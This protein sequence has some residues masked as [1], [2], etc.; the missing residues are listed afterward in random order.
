MLHKITKRVTALCLACVLLATPIFANSEGLLDISYVDIEGKE[1]VATTMDGVDALYNATSGYYYCSELVPRYYETVYGVEIRIGDGKVTVLNS[2]DI[3]FVETDT[4]SHGDIMYGSPDAR[5]KSY[6]HWGIVKDCDETSV[7][8]FE[9]NWSWNGQAGVDRVIEFPTTYY[10]F[11]TMVSKSGNLPEAVGLDSDSI[12]L[13]TASDW[14][15]TYG[16][17]AEALIDI[18]VSYQE[19]ISRELFC[20]LAAAVAGEYGIS[21]LGTTGVEQAVNLG[22]ISNSESTTL[23]RQEAAVIS[24]RLLDMIGEAPVADASVLDI[25]SDVEAIGAWSADSVATLTACGF[26]CGSEGKFQPQS[27][28]TVEQGVV[29]LMQV[30]ENPAPVVTAVT[31]EAPAA[32]CASMAVVRLCGDSMFLSR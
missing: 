5:G 25:Y 24:V 19:T 22:L 26:F 3:Y 1:F 6:S 18:D 13:A 10:K 9:Q 7:T 30:A 17:S 29:L 23:T 27:G 11:Y 4:P 31:Y 28:L 12:G 2:S 21:A 15:V 32:D 16:E 8:I 20:Q 14:A